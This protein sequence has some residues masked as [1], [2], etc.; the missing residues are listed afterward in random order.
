MDGLRACPKCG[1]KMR[2]RKPK[3]EQIVEAK[4]AGHEPRTPEPKIKLQPLALTLTL[5][6]QVTPEQLESLLAKVFNMHRQSG[7]T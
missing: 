4:P 1:Y 5:N 3:S 6:L 7:S 2:G